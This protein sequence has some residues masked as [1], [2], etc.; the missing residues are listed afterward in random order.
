MTG[1]KNGEGKRDD[2]DDGQDD[3]LHDYM[4]QLLAE[5]AVIEEEQCPF[6]YR[7]ICEG[8]FASYIILTCNL[9]FSYRN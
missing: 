3:K 8:T 1:Y 4:R 5:K 7:F 2:R 6:A 9:I